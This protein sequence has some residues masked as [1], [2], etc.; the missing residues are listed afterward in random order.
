M[1]E[2]V[3]VPRT[4]FP[5]E[6][7]VMDDMV[8]DN[9]LERAALFLCCWCPALPPPLPGSF[10]L[11]PGTILAPKLDKM[12]VGSSFRISLKYGKLEP[13]VKEHLIVEFL[14]QVGLKD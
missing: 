1:V 2:M 14:N 9:K 12:K 7:S 3:E 10:L 6:K 13:L 5:Y 8:V 11:W 4:V